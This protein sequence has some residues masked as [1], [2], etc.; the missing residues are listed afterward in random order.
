M[1]K[2]AS[3]QL[4]DTRRLPRSSAKAF[5][6]AAHGLFSYAAIHD[7][8]LYKALLR[9]TS[10]HLEAKVVATK[11]VKGKPEMGT[12]VF[13]V[14]DIKCGVKIIA[15]KAI[16]LKAKSAQTLADARYTWAPS[17]S[18]SASAGYVLS[19][20]DKKFS[21]AAR[22]INAASGDSSS[23]IRGDWYRGG[24]ILIFVAS[25]D[26]AAGEQLLA[27]YALDTKKVYIKSQGRK[28]ALC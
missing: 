4:V 12:G 24:R 18:A 14:K 13:A 3:T 6:K 1:V 15:A 8:G 28:G 19:Q 26:I 23:N 10:P 22:Y 11:R 2:F 7:T 5:R 17:A 20:Y 27:D 9:G 25:R 16:A 21:N